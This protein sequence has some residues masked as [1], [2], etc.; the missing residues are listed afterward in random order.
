MH[1][2]YF[3]LSKE[4]LQTFMAIKNFS[5]ILQQRFGLTPALAPQDHPIDSVKFTVPRHSFA[6]P[7]H[8]TRSLRVL[9]WGR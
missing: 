9:V 5:R 8:C 6:E 1:M 4:E 7:G 2:G 3:Q